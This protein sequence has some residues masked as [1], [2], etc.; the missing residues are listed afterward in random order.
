MTPFDQE[1]ISVPYTAQDA[2]AE[3]VDRIRSYLQDSNTYLSTSQKVMVGL[4]L[5]R[6]DLLEQ[7]GY[8]ASD[9]HSA[10]ARLNK[11]QC[12]AIISWWSE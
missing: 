1:E 10:W 6:P 9:I 2:L 11:H 12:Q 4:A 7:A 8:P 3:N 5:C